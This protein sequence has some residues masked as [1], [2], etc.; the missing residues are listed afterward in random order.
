MK[1]LLWYKNQNYNPKQLVTLTGVTLTFLLFVICLKPDYTG[2]RFIYSVLGIY[3]IKNHCIRESM[4]AQNIIKEIKQYPKKSCYNTYRGWTQ[5]EY[6][7]KHRNTDRKEE[8]T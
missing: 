7:N 1:E 6:R 3:L 2:N 8:G 5:T 4:G